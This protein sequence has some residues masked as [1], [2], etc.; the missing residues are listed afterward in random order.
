M[1]SYREAAAVAAVALVRCCSVLQAML[2]GLREETVPEVAGER[3][4]A[5]VLEVF[6]AVEPEEW[7]IH[8]EPTVDLRGMIV[9]PSLAMAV[10]IQAWAEPIKPAVAW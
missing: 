5:M 7:E 1:E 2:P 9:V 4:R 10:E 6:L 3:T 8:R